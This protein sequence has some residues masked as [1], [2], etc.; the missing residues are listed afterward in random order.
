MTAAPLPSAGSHGH[1]TPHS[2]DDSLRRAL[3][4]AHTSRTPLA[5]GRHRRGG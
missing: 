3:G 5:C 1:N 4:R 2:A